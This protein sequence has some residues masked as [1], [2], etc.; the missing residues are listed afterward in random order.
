MA[1]SNF[2]GPQFEGMWRD[3]SW[4]TKLTDLIHGSDIAPDLL[5]S[6]LIGRLALT[7]A[8]KQK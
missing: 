5:D 3:K 4:H 2:C 7:G 6:P 1:T 8:Y